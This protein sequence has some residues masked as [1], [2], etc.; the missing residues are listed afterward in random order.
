MI[1]TRRSDSAEVNRPPEREGD[2]RA[3]NGPDAAAEGPRTTIQ[4]APIVQEGAWTGTQPPAAVRRTPAT[5]GQRSRGHSTP[6]VPT[7]RGAA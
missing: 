6:I 7:T 1:L 2:A 3:A 4:S 5:H